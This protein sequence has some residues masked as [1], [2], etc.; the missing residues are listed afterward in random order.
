MLKMM[1]NPKIVLILKK[2]FGRHGNQDLLKSFI[3][4]MKSHNE[5]LKTITLLNPYNLTF[6]LEKNLP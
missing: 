4:S 6:Y 5:K 1:V 3:N 2:I